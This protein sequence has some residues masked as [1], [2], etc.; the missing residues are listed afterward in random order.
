MM[1]ADRALAEK[2]ATWHRDFGASE[3]IRFRFQSVS[4][5]INKRLRA[6]HEGDT[7]LQRRFPDFRD[8]RSHAIKLGSDLMRD[9]RERERRESQQRADERARARGGQSMRKFNDYLLG[10]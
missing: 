8:F 10:R 5:Y 4:R 7:D 9:E 6:A 2:M 3:E 1:D